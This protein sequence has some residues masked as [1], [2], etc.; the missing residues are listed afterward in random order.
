M[1]ANKQEIKYNIQMPHEP[2]KKNSRARQG[3]R[4]AS[5]KLKNPCFVTCAN[6]KNLILT[7]RVCEKC[8]YYNGKQVLKI[9]I[10]GKKQANEEKSA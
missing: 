6:C 4:R 1:L 8:G 2:K 7:H 10:K 3:K 9:K 5:I